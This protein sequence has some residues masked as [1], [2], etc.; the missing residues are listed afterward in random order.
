MKNTII[1]DKLQS[2]QN[3][4]AL[5]TN[6]NI[7][8]TKTLDYKNAH[9]RK[10][11]VFFG[12][13]KISRCTNLFGEFVEFNR[14]A[15]GFTRQAG[16]ASF[17]NTSLIIIKCFRVCSCGIQYPSFRTT[18]WNVH[19]DQTTNGDFLNLYLTPYLYTIQYIL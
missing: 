5:N 15:E 6:T 8:N 9:I 17:P 12:P 4:N 19:G 18:D 14:A 11:F 13:L 7:T 3:G 2:D 1:W 16:K 10:M